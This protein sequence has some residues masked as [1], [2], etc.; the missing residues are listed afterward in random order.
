MLFSEPGK[1]I[2]S[3]KSGTRSEEQRDHMDPGNVDQG[4][5]CHGH[6][7]IVCQVVTILS[8]TW[9]VNAGGP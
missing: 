2:A 4:D 1:G 8:H 3:H 7:K 9:M 6:R 5:S